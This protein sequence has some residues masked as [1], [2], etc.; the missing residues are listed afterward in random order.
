MQKVIITA[1]RVNLQNVLGVS[2]SLPLFQDFVLC[3]SVGWHGIFFVGTAKSARAISLSERKKGD[4]SKEWAFYV[5]EKRVLA[6]RGA[7][8]GFSKA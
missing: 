3:A 5:F 2:P 6:F 8:F 1:F 4:G 7:N